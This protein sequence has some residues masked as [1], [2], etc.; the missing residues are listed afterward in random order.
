MVDWRGWGQSAMGKC[1]F[2]Y[3]CNLFGAVVLHRAM[4]DQRRGHGVSLPWVY[5][6]S[7]IY[8]TY[9][10]QWFFRDL[11][12]TGGGGVSLPLVY[13]HSAI[14]VTYSVQWFFRDP[15]L[16]GGDGVS[17]PWV[18][19]HSA[20][21]ETYLVQWFF[22]DLW[23]IGGREGVSLPWEYVHSSICETY[24]VQWFS[25]DLC[26]IGG[27]GVHLHWDSISWVGPICRGVHLPNISSLQNLLLLH[28]GLFYER[29]IIIQSS[30]AKT[31][32]KW[33]TFCR[34]G[35]GSQQ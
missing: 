15:C 30:L 33:F 31:N 9:L 25:R 29:P 10:V 13:V 1:A 16:I 20:I 18:Y 12:L 4:V 5:V 28:R 2:C 8:E 32:T 27:G 7:A 14:Y 26:L 11:W 6:H 19:V 22:R 3:I 17:L 35:K 21:Y 24:L 23:L 34:H